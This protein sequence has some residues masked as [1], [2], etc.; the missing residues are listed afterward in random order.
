MNN[1]SVQAGMQTSDWGGLGIKKG[2]PNGGGQGDVKMELR[3]VIAFFPSRSNLMVSGVW[4]ECLLIRL[5]RM[6]GQDVAVKGEIDGKNR[7]D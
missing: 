4:G 1:D 2:S 7:A 6:Q 3:Y 5:E